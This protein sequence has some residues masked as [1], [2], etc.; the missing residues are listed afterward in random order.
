M[1]EQNRQYEIS[2]KQLQAAERQIDAINL[3]NNKVKELNASVRALE[4][5]NCNQLQQFS[6]QMKFMVSLLICNIFYF[7]L[8]LILHWICKLY[9]IAKHFF[10]LEF[11]NS[12]TGSCYA[13]TCYSSIRSSTNI[14]PQGSQCWQGPDES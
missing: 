7:L 11:T 9:F 2:R 13:G 12:K 4:N 14:D 5:R 3:L 10:V 6:N 8:A 1:V